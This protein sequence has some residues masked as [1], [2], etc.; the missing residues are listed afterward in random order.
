MDPARGWR[1]KLQGTFFIRSPRGRGHPLCIGAS[2]R[3]PRFRTGDVRS[4]ALGS[5][6][7]RGCALKSTKTRSLGNVFPRLRLCEHGP[8]AGPAGRWFCICVVDNVCFRKQSQQRLGST[9]VIWFQVKGSQTSCRSRGPSFDGRTMFFRRSMEVLFWAVEADL[10]DMLWGNP[11][12][13]LQS[14]RA[15]L[16]S[17]N[18]LGGNWFSFLASR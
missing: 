13:S 10:G 12:V 17:S 2:I 6:F 1:L 8:Q 11:F 3:H 16:V 15:H 7:W 4:G 5:F 18:C 9:R 14:Q